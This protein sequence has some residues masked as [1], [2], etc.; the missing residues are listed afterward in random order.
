MQGLPIA[1]IVPPFRELEMRSGDVRKPLN[2]EDY[3]REP[4]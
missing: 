3:F 2:N 4:L 1:G